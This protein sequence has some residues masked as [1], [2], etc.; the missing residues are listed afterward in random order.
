MLERERG[1]E[2]TRKVDSGWWWKFRWPQV[3]TG[4][5]LDGVEIAELHTCQE[6]R[7]SLNRSHASERYILIQ[8]MCKV[9]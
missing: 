7:D 4:R 8:S 3:L 5:K 6:K 1:T 9:E 2:K